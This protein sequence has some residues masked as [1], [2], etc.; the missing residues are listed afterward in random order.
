MP[1]KCLFDI[2]NS[3]FLS[4]GLPYD[5]R[6]SPDVMEERDGYFTN[7]RHR[8]EAAVSVNGGIPGVVV[9]HSVSQMPFLIIL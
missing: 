8:I 4:E 5:W 1:L 7:V 9:A 3:I 2:N 6:L